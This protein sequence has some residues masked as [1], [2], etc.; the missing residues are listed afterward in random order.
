MHLVDCN[1]IIYRS[2]MHGVNNLKKILYF[3]VFLFSVYTLLISHKCQ[4]P[5]RDLNYAP[6]EF[7]T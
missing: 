2:D 1:N 3:L 4:F 5:G 7:E 6:S